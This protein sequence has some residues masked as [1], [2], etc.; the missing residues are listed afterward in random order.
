[1]SDNLGSKA[2][3]LLGVVA[4]G[5]AAV[6]AFIL[7]HASEELG[8]MGGKYLGISLLFPLIVVFGCCWGARKILPAKTQDLSVAIGIVSGQVVL[9]LIGGLYFGV[10]QRVLLDIVILGAGVTWLIVRPSVWPIIGLTAFE[11]FALGS[12]ILALTQV[13]D[14]AAAFKG[15]ISFMLI[16]LAAII[17][18][19]AGYKTLNSRPAVTVESPE[20]GV[21]APQSPARADHRLAT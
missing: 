6:G 10:L 2:K 1:M 15:L 19:V 20:A 13:T 21:K 5:A 11:I 8:K 3:G 18:L 14:V 4:A 12:N 16:R 17:F 7:T 9:H